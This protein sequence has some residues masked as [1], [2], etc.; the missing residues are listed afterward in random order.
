MKRALPILV[1]SIVVGT[2]MATLAWAKRPREV[3]E[4]DH[5][6]RNHPQL[7]QRLAADPKLADDPEFLAKHPALKTFLI[8]HP[9]AKPLIA[10]A[11]ERYA[12]GA[13]DAPKA[14]GP[15]TP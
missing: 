15:P 7:A 14:G 1:T 5:F 13:P 9:D 2:M 8:A 6:L 10:S 12:A 11:A 3:A 4:V